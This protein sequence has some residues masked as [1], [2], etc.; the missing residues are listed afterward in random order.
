M[1]DQG[2]GVGSSDQSRNSGGGDKWSDLGHP[3]EVN[4]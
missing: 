1:A 3:L 2:G 4:L